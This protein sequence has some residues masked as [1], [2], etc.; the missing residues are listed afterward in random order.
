MIA[1]IWRG[2]IKPDQAGEYV[3]YVNR[4]GIRDHRKAR[5]NLASVILTRDQGD[6]TEILVVSLWESMD[7]VAGFVEPPTERAVYYPEDRDYLLELEPYV[8]HYEVPVAEWE[9]G[10]RSRLTD[11]GPGGIG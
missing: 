4:T 5:G 6:E 1:R 3:E 9:G 7:A 11:L 8:L 10:H 2:R